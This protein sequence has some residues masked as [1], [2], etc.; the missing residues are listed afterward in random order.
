MR[1]SRLL[2]SSIVTVFH[3]IKPICD[4][5][6]MRVCNA[7]SFVVERR[8]KIKTLIWFILYKG[9]KWLLFFLKK[10][11]NLKLLVFMWIFSCELDIFSFTCFLF[12]RFDS[13]HSSV[14][15]FV[16]CTLFPFTFERKGTIISPHLQRV[17]FIG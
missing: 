11:T 2:N 4:L 9:Y 15:R 1:T 8:W 16:S 13:K 3:L 17:S 14:M 7:Q 5:H 10:K 6:L 12:F